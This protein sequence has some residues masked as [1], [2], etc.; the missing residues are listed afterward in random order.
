MQRM[1][2]STRGNGQCQYFNNGV[3]FG[4]IIFS[5]SWH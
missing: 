2:Y 5:S 4:G 1:P 3:I